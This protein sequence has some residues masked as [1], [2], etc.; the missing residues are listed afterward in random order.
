MSK[1]TRLQFI[2]NSSKI[3][4]GA[5]L[6]SVG[7]SGFAKGQKVIS[8]NDKISI[9]LIGCNGV[10]WVD[11]MA[12]LAIKEVQC[13]AL[14]DIDDGVLQS[15][16]N[17]IEKRTGTRPTGYKDFRHLLDRKDIDAV[18]IG[19]PDHWHA[20]LTIF[21]TEAGKDVYV[22]KPLANSIEECHAIAKAVKRY[23]RVVQVG[24][25]QRSGEHWNNALDFVRSGKLGDIQNIKVW[26]CSN[27]RNE[28]AVLPDQ[29]V[30]ADIDYDMWLGPAPK[31]AFN[32][33]RFH[34]NWRSYWDY[35][36]GL[37]TDWGVHMIDM[38]LS[39]MN[40]TEPKSV[41]A[42]G[43]KLVFPNSPVE[44]PDTLQAI[45][46]FDKFNLVSSQVSIVV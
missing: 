9:G 16:L 15:R 5:S 23:N 1:Y 4:A 34:K 27:T 2:Y 35:G 24:L 32:Q 41:V 7:I 26:A 40:A 38:A 3:L 33:N 19:T 29:P 30:P 22:E 37:M 43:G 11:L 28:V 42:Q 46:Q 44:T 20:L 45:F 12:H 6:V 21:A 8:P 17:E 14:C 39:G 10:G 36:G 25:Q 13:L 18:I 31:R